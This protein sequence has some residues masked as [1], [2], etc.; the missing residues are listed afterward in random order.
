MDRT[1]AE[2]KQGSMFIKID[3]DSTRYQTAIEEIDRYIMPS[4]IWESKG[5]P[6]SS[7]HEYRDIREIKRSIPT[8]N[9]AF[10]GSDQYLPVGSTKAKVLSTQMSRKTT[11]DVQRSL[12]SIVNS[13][14]E[15]GSKMAMRK[16]Y[17]SFIEFQ[18]K[19]EFAKCNELLISV[20]VNE[21]SVLVLL[22]LLMA[23]FSM[24][25]MLGYRD[26][27]Y[28]KVYRKVLLLNSPEEADK[29]LGTLR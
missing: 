6:V 27:F 20:N 14:R 1:E 8:S 23:S 9:C 22:S 2:L 11:F 29:M 16:V 5:Y 28:Q 3:E 18:T 7:Y 19:K 12:E 24:K 17:E 4:M 25:K 15:E 21:T 13:Q 26:S 10:I